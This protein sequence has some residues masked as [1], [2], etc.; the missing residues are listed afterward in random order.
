MAAAMHN[1]LSS[2][3]SGATQPI[4]SNL[5]SRIS[6]TATSDV[7]KS[8]E[9]V[10]TQ[11]RSA[12]EDDTPRPAKKRALSEGRNEIYGVEVPGDSFAPWLDDNLPCDVGASGEE[13]LHH[14]LSQFVAYIHPSENEREARR[15]L[16]ARIETLLQSR[17]SDANV[18][19]FGSSA[20][21]LELTGGDIDLV[22]AFNHRL[23]DPEKKRRLAA[24]GDVLRRSGI[25]T[26]VNRIF[27]ATVPIITFTSTEAL[28]EVSVDISIRNDEDSGPRAIPVVKQFLE[29]MGPS[30]R[31]L[32]L[33]VKAFLSLRDLNDASQSTLSSYAI[34]ILCISFLQRNPSRRPQAFLDDP[35]GNKALGVLLMDFF[36][37]YG[38]DFSYATHYISVTDKGIFTKR[39][40]NWEQKG[41]AV[42][43]VQCLLNPDK[44]ITRGCSKIHLIVEA[45]KEADYT[46]QNAL[47]SV[48]HE[49]STS[50]LSGIYEVPQEMDAKRR[51]LEDAVI[52][53][54]FEKAAAACTAGRAEGSTRS[55]SGGVA[56]A[57]RIGAGARSLPSNPARSMSGNRGTPRQSQGGQGGQSWMNQNQG[58][59]QQLPILRWRDSQF[60][61]QPQPS[62]YPPMSFT[63]QVDPM[64]LG[65]QN[66]P[67]QQAFGYGH[68]QGNYN[69]GYNNNYYVPQH[70]QNGGQYSH[71]GSLRR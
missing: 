47:L 32:I 20:T 11:K 3:S 50:L 62:N 15:L 51:A 12:S 19:L 7:A 64:F 53:G 18:I 68:N 69:N 30:L 25:T 67:Q 31:P 70:R 40:K 26:W 14:E 45:F 49:S 10:H 61:F 71:E 65:F 38:H 58:S 66:R 60:N 4:P 34:T 33:A 22:V 1:S 55:V 2:S 54:S 28:G 23:A 24:M 46:L 37:H 41:Q 63:P 8:V 13:R 48:P 59:I 57:T 42:L 21:G 43:A 9:M 16:V 44:N 5:L 29:T 56:L 39:S 17:W 52:S 36:R 35:L 27:S 6:M